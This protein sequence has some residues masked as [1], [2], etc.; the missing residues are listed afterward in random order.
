MT[1]IIVC[2]C[3]QLEIYLHLQE[4]SSTVIGASLFE[5]YGGKLFDLLNDREPVKCLENHQGRFCK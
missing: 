4:E 1:I 5:I 3:L 2:I